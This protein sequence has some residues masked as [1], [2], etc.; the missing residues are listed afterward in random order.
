MKVDSFSIHNIRHS[1]STLAK[2]LRC[3]SDEITECLLAGGVLGEE[4]AGD[5]KRKPNEH[6]NVRF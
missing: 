2:E 5:I 6:L 3:T 1:I 4:E